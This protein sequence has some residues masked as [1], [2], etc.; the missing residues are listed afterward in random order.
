MGWVPDPPVWW[1]VGDGE[2]ERRRGEEGGEGV[3]GE[4]EESEGRWEGQIFCLP[5]LSPSFLW[6]LS[7]YSYNS[8]YI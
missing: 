6:H 4:G 1:G 8:F 2:G 3:K 5:F 7:V